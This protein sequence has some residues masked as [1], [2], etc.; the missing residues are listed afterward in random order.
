MRACTS[1][2]RP[3]SC[4]NKYILDGVTR[5]RNLVAVEFHVCLVVVERHVCLVVAVER[6]VCLV[7]IV[8]RDVCLR[9]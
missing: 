8:E 6:H 3:T 5:C 2:A 7:A 4:V 1:T 9:W